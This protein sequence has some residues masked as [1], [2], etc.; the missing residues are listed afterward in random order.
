MRT[1]IS[2]AIRSYFGYMAITT[3]LAASS[4]IWKDKH[5]LTKIRVCPFLQRF[6]YLNTVMWE[7]QTLS[8]C[9]WQMFLTG[10]IP[11]FGKGIEPFS[12]LLNTWLASAC[13]F[14]RYS[15]WTISIFSGTANTRLNW[16]G[17]VFALGPD[18]LVESL[19]DVTNITRA[20]CTQH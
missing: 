17:F 3:S 5:I 8:D 1:W 20:G 15:A 14:H 13:I 2:W 19:L 7:R 6:L 12:R 16:M 10:P 11:T 18:I 4:K 9:D